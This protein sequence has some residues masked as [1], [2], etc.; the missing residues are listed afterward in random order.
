MYWTIYGFAEKIVSLF[1]SGPIVQFRCI[2]TAVFAGRSQQI[3][4][5]AIIFRPE[6]SGSQAQSAPLQP[7]V[8]C[9][10]EQLLDVK[11]SV[12]KNHPRTFS[13]QLDPAKF[14][15]GSYDLLLHLHPKGDS[16]AMTKLH[17]FDASDVRQPFTLS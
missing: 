12:E 11:L 14:K 9:E 15:A 13:A 10:G 4:I 2:P 8:T 1:R 17:V 6:R 7:T 5:E 3:P 16:V